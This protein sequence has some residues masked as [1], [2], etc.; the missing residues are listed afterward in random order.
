[1]AIEAG[2]IVSRLML[3]MTDFKKAMKSAPGIAKKDLAKVNTAM[4]TTMRQMDKSVKGFVDKSEAHGKKFEKGWWARFGAVALGFTIA[5]RAMNVFE[6][7]LRKLA[8]TTLDAIRESGELASLQAK[9][10]LWTTMHSKGLI[11]YGE[12]FTYARGTMLALM[13]ASVTSLSSIEELS[14]G[15][16]EMGQTLGMI[17]T[18]TV[19]AAVDLVDFTVLVAQTTGSVTRQVRQ[20]IQSLLQGQIRTTD[21]VIRTMKKMGVVTDEDI[22]KLKDQIDVQETFDK[23]L[24]AISEHMEE[25]RRQ[26]LRTDVNKALAYWE[27]SIRVVL[28]Q[29]ILLA[30]AY[31]DVGNIFAEELV[32]R[33][34]K[35][36]DA[37]SPKD[38]GRIAVSLQG[39]RSAFALGL[40]MFES[41]IKVASTL[42]TV[43]T[44]L[45]DEI[46]LVAKGL[47]LL[48]AAGLVTKAFTLLGAT[49]LWLYATPLK[50]LRL[51][52]ASLYLKIMAIPVAAFAAYVALETLG[53]MFPD[54]EKKA[55]DAG[56]KIGDFMFG[57]WERKLAKDA[58]S[59]WKKAFPELFK[60]VEDVGEEAAEFWGPLGKEAGTL[61]VENLTKHLDQLTTLLKP[62][63]DK[64]K[65]SMSDLALPDID[66]DAAMAA[67]K[68]L[69]NTNLEMMGRTTDRTKDL[70][71]ETDKYIKK[72]EKINTKH[73]ITLD[74]L[75]RLKEGE[76]QPEDVAFETKLLALAHERL[77]A[78]EKM[79][80]ALLKVVIQYTAIAEKELI[81]QKDLKRALDLIKERIDLEAELAQEIDDIAAAN[82][83]VFDAY[84]KNAIHAYT[85]IRDMYKDMLDAGE[86]YGAEYNRAADKLLEL[87]KERMLKEIEDYMDTAEAKMLV[88][89]WANNEKKKLYEARRDMH[90]EM[91]AGMMND[92]AVFFKYMSQENQ[93]YFVWFKRAAIAETIIKTIQA[94]Q[95]SYAWA[96]SWG[97]PIAGAIAATIASL[98]GFARVAMISAQTYAVGGWLDK[99]PKGGKVGEGSGTRD[100]VFLGATPGVRHWVMKDEFIFVMN[101]KAT[102]Q[103]GAT[104]E[105][106]NQGLAGG[107]WVDRGYGFFS[108]IVDIFTGKATTPPATTAA[109][110]VSY[111]DV[112]YEIRKMLDL[113]TALEEA[114][115]STGKKFKDW[116]TELQAAGASAEQLAQVTAW[117]VEV[118]EYLVA[119]MKH[120]AWTKIREKIADL[121]DI[122]T[123]FER[124]VLSISE[125]FDDMVESLKDVEMA[126]DSA[127]N[128]TAE[129]VAVESARIA[130]IRHLVKVQQDELKVEMTER[131]AAIR[132][133]PGRLTQ[134]DL[135]QEFIA[136]MDKIYE[137]YEATGVDYS[138]LTDR[139]VSS[140]EEIIE[141]AI[142]QSEAAQILRDAADE[143]QDV[144]DSL[145]DAIWDMQTTL[146]SP[147]DIFERM[148]LVW[149][150]ILNL[151][152]AGAT[153]PEEVKK[154]QELYLQY[155]DLA[156][157]AYQRPSTEYQAIYNTILSSLEALETQ[158]E[159]FISSYQVQLDTLITGQMQLTTQEGM[160]MSLVEIADSIMA[161]IPV[162][163][164]LTTDDFNIVVDLS[165]AL[166]EVLPAIL[167]E[168]IS[169]PVLV[170]VTP[171]PIAAPVQQTLFGPTG[172]QPWKIRGPRPDIPNWQPH[173]AQHGG[174]FV[175][176]ESGYPVMLH[177]IERVTPLGGAG[178]E[179]QF[180]MNLTINESRTPHETGRVVTDAIKGF[181]KSGQGRKLV[182]DTSIGR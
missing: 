12:A 141:A 29:S 63:L 59:Y 140:Y 177:G 113:T 104:L 67:L 64:I 68:E 39:L 47:G 37:L 66:I 168:P 54:L 120:E 178:G 171:E 163:V 71:K 153:T 10:A 143:W 23:V 135:V 36:R 124:Q 75:E 162:D 22:A 116:Y 179:A 97:G 73:L 50:L 90:F 35:F 129:L 138:D 93:K 172:T 6:R 139:V 123:P 44:N 150:E 34:E 119:K 79:D 144:A 166:E 19:G 158:T 4:K 15:L 152:E 96:A 126:F 83:K 72:L 51:A 147:A 121:L 80:P 165:D 169:A 60:I 76:L 27:K 134:W 88:D 94:A 74:I 45:Y 156:Q 18:E 128:A 101:K 136:E 107:G 173:W 130:A 3:D 111:A 137:Q 70:I 30:S 100:D 154:L 181:L 182:R 5:Y 16:D 53:D 1:M 148:S 145:S 28:V 155:L 146:T 48:L 98:A 82:K 125:Q 21:I 8:D 78:V 57:P 99:H 84:E 31:E 180:E 52:F 170:P 117:R 77:K 108:D 81:A 149:G 42:I 106:M 40:D 103:H 41:T 65:E 167:T 89:E 7:G 14:T 62:V 26:V 109:S 91:T 105:A 127:G 2:S 11:K 160:A 161:G 13:E 49:A 151:E 46:V 110:A 95:A 25:F 164:A 85:I 43:F 24:V 133:E 33:A 17:R 87:Q 56:K 69:Q 142:L 122:F 38:I 55:K 132:L 32:Q 112:Q 131:L 114:L 20:E 58:I 174:T 157:E 61:Y 9:L 92:L 115:R 159:G 86:G 176:P 175:G 102:K 118:E